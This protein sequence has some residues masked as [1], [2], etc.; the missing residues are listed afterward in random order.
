MAFKS[1][2]SQQKICFVAWVLGVG[3]IFF[4]PMSF[5][6]WP[7]ILLFIAVILLSGWLF[8]KLKKNS[9]AFFVFLFILLSLLFL[10]FVVPAL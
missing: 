3:G 6:E 8:Y 1:F 2:L 9:I 5:P 7:A 10:M 4:Y